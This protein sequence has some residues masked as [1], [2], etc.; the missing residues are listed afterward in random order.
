M[1]AFASFGPT[2]YVET[3][4][5]LGMAMPIRMCIMRSERLVHEIHKLQVWMLTTSECNNSGA[6]HGSNGPT[7]SVRQFKLLI[8]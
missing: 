6:H 2:F 8:S 3:L 4:G 5:F 7:T 1:C